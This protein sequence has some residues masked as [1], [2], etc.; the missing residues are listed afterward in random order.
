[1]TPSSDLIHELK[2]SRPSAPLALR[3]RVREIAA[4]ETT[5][6]ARR[7]PRFALPL[8]RL[9]LVAVPAAAA[10]ALAAA[11]VVGLARSDGELEASRAGK[12]ATTQET[13]PTSREGV[14]G[15]LA[16]ATPQ[17]TTAADASVAPTPGRVQQVSATLTV[18][19]RDS[20]GVSTASQEALALTRRL[21]G[22]VVSASV[23]TGDEAGA[24]LTVRVPVLKVQDAIVGLS[25][26]GSIVSQQVAIEDLQEQVDTYERRQRSLRAQIAGVRAR[27]ES[28]SL[29][30][31]TRARLETRL[32]S[33]R[34]ELRASRRSESATRAQGRMATIQLSV[35]TPESGVAA[36][37]SRLD[38]T[39]DEALNVLVW[40]AVVALAVLI[41]VA[42][43]ALVFFAVW[44]GRRLYR[45]REEDR[46]LA[47]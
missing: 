44:L 7:R 41:V 24:L 34:D 19:V 5:A 25:A 11:G 2:A 26:L 29:D 46:L 3:A 15:E 39:L 28:N 32:K 38:R 21:G 42:P 13:T 9:S 40:E 6:T 17:V 4:Q 14:V 1:M 8:R 22:H 18:E 20:D 27:L 35:V 33:L 43:F 37:G 30:A 36:P 47:A 10:L 31:E 45:R 23:T 12:D 16:P